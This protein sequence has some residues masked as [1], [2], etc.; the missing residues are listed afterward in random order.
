MVRFEPT[1]AG[2]ELYIKAKVRF[3]WLYTQKSFLRPI[4]LPLLREILSYFP[5]YRYYPLLSSTQL[6]LFD[7][8]KASFLSLGLD[9]PCSAGSR[10]ALQSPFTVLITG[11][12]PPKLQAY[13]VSLDPCSFER[14]E[15]MLEPR[16]YHGTL[17]YRGFLWVFGGSGQR[18]S[19]ERWGNDSES[20]EIVG[21]MH[22]PR[23]CFT[24]CGYEGKIYLPEIS[25]LFKP[26]E[27][28]DIGR[29]EFFLLPFSVES[30]YV[31]SVSCLIAEELVLITHAGMLGRWSLQNDQVPMVFSLIT[32]KEK[33][34]MPSDSVLVHSGNWVYVVG[35]DREMLKL[36]LRPIK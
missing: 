11:A 25:E 9:F 14:L 4:S 17:Y 26:F 35:G 15:P 5:T 12:Q 16:G 27:M 33:E 24:P 13:R 2:I 32:I 31:G 34:V 3:F 36:D 6:Y 23:S 28:L 8:E 21:E 7:L 20:W 1:K 22:Y 10:C 18:K 29:M 30:M 19:A